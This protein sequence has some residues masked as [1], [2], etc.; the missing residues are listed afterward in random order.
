MYFDRR[1]RPQHPCTRQPRGHVL[2]KGPAQIGA[3][4]IRLR[5]DLPLHH[6]GKPATDCLDFGQFGHLAGS[7]DMGRIVTATSRSIRK[8]GTK[9][10]NT[11]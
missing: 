4:H 9:D 5:D 3:V 11:P 1:R 7:C 6:G 10:N 2:G 8:G